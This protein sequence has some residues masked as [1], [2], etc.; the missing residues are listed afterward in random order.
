M[1]ASSGFDSIVTSFGKF[2]NQNIPTADGRSCNVKFD[3]FFIGFFPSGIKVI[4]FSY[5]F[6]VPLLKVNCI[7]IKGKSMNC[8]MVYV[9]Q[10][11]W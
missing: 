8:I 6:S 1:Q 3:K 11:S 4:F 9:V 10:C 7:V 5:F 2:V